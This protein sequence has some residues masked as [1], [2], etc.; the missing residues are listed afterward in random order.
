MSVVDASGSVPSHVQAS[1]CATLVDQFALDGVTHAFIAPGSRSTPM[2]V[3][4]ARHPAFRVTVTIDERT[5]AFAGL[6]SGLATGRP[7][8]VLCTSGTAATHFHAAVVEADLSA[9][10]LIVLTADRPPELRDVAAPQTINQT[11]I[12]GDAVRW[13]H[14]PGVP[15][16]EAAMSWRSL[17]RRT[18]WLSTGRAPGPVHLNLPFREP[19]LADVPVEPVP[20]SGSSSLQ[21]AAQLV[22]PSA[23]DELAAQVSGRRGVLVVGRGSPERGTVD[24][25]AARLGWP[26]MAEPRAGCTGAASSV[27]HFDAVLRVVGDDESLRPEVVIRVGE[28]P[29]SKVLAQWITR[30]GARQIHVTA[31]PRVADSDHSMDA[32]VEGDTGGILRRLAEVSTTCDPAWAGRWRAMSAAASGAI[33]AVLD[34]T[35]EVAPLSVVFRL[36]GSLPVGG[37]LVVSSS[38][39]VR[40]LEWFGGDCDHLRVFANRGA[41]GIDGVVATALGVASSGG[42]PTTVLIGD[43]A[44]VHDLSSVAALATSGLPVTLVVC[45]NDGGGIFEFLPQ[46]EL[47]DRAS[48][49]Q[50]FGTPHGLDL[51]AVLRGMGLPVHQPESMVG[52]VDSMSTPGPA[53]VMVRSRREDDVDEH[54][55]LQRVVAEAL[56]V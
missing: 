27:R 8:L 13:F 16:I 33:R 39:P 40:N 20:A 45:D 38:M 28:A 36:P 48:F 17:A 46:A 32:R 18:V 29:A 21:L 22:D 37:N 55:R 3:A 43:V 6:G 51:A 12:F 25:L 1:F 24:A 2:A 53:V 19:L 47:L 7:A 34:A 30:S 4:I 31:S 56:R 50:L 9:V 35:D 14:D 10:P 44:L 23:V 41:N 42:G 52:L 49:E 11:R 5:A 26:V 15:V 54:R